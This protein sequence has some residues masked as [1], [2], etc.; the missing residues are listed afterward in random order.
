MTQ[1]VKVFVSYSWTTENETHIVEEL[2]KLCPQRGIELIRD[3]EALKHGDSIDKF[4]KELSRGDHVITVFSKP[5]FRSK[6]CMYE[7]LSI[8][9]RGDFAERTHPVIADDCN[10]QDS[11]Y[12]LE[13]VEFWETKLKDNK[14]DLAGF[15]P[16]VVLKEHEQ[17]KLCRDIYQNI[18]EILHF[19]ADRVTTL[20]PKLRKEN[21]AQMLDRIASTIEP[22]DNE[23]IRT[24]KTKISDELQVSELVLFRDTL[25]QEL[26]KCAPKFNLP[27]IVDNN[28]GLLVDGLIDLFK[29]NSTEVPVITTVLTNAAKHCL[30]K[31]G[32][33]YKAC[34][35]KQEPIKEA[36]EQIL[37]WLVVA[38]V[39][40]AYVQ[41]LNSKTANSNIFFI[42]PVVTDAGVE[43]VVSRNFQRQAQLTQCNSDIK[44]QF[45]LST[46]S[47]RF[48]SWSPEETAET[49]KREIWNQVFPDKNKE[50]NL[51]DD[52][53]EK[54]NAEL[55]IRRI[56]HWHSE[57]HVLAIRSDN[58][59]QDFPQ[60]DV[61][62]RL[63][64]E[65]SNLT[66]VQFGKSEDKPVFYAPEHHL[67]SA[68]N[69]FLKNI[70]ATLN[71]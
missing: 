55:E 67:M 12:R 29:T 33:H 3:N 57:H 47:S 70:N 71:S 7:L 42:L 27:E 62:R 60:N 30:D 28:T 61:Y 20:L 56:D 69:R 26:N 35:D 36:I 64:T 49:L 46:K 68:I 2:G 23:F 63:L 19:A 41:T 66:L 1:P 45:L 11:K 32:K 17:A 5:Y 6:W 53:T 43:I 38:S 13:I 65:L 9:Q 18:D 16:K 59:E 4:M 40:E 24:V 34:L 10:L 48:S 52:E 37:G 44:G 31:K 22:A 25:K 8:Y 51:N 21:Y 54:L 58:I 50:N 14:K 39:D 15:D